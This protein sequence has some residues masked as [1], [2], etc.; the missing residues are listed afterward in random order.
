MVRYWGRTMGS[1]LDRACV[2]S[3]SETSRLANRLSS[4][5]YHYL[6]STFLFLAV[7]PHAANGR[8]RQIQGL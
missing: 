1:P 8:S 3:H 7:A 5:L 4:L 2:C 6:L